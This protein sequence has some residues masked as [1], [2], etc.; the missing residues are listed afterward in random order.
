MREDLFDLSAEVSEALLEGLPIVALETAV[1]T[2]GLPRPANL[3]AYRAIE[4]A[5]RTEG[6]VP[7]AVALINGT[8]RVGLS[9][10]DVELLGTQELVEKVG[11][12]DLPSLAAQRASGGSTVA[13]TLWAASRANI[14]VFATGGIG[15]VH[16]G[17]EATFDVSGDLT[18]LARFGGCVVCSGAKVILDLPK[19]AELMECLGVCVLGYR[20]DEL[21]AFTCRHSGLRVR[22]RVNTP[23]EVASVVRSR[24]LLGLPQAVV[25][26]NPPP[27]ER[28]LPRELLEKALGSA[29][30]AAAREGVGGKDLTPYLLEAVSRATGGASVAANRA[31]LMEN[32]TL[33]ARIS[34]ALAERFHS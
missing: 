22:H 2:H 31:L 30:E 11:L 20:T 10:E 27:P 7:A 23:E 32:A 13:V 8:V 25:V 34:R 21:P 28:A 12:S 24:D 17:A 4:E 19:T 33:G 14:R 26:A 6:A 15:G 5:V 29:V 18:A 3:E 16:R 9:A 1:L